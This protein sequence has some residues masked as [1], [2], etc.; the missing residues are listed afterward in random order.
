MSRYHLTA[1][2]RALY[3]VFIAPNLS[4]K[5][6]LLGQRP[7]ILAHSPAVVPQTPIRYKTYKKSE[8]A[9]RNALSDQYTLDGAINASHINLID[10]SGAFQPNF[11]TQRVSYN[12]VTHHLVLLQPGRVDEFGRSDPDHLPTCKIMSKMDLRAQHQKKLDIERRKAKGQAGSGPSP[13]NLE[14]NWAIASGDLK[15]RLE[16]LKGFLREGRKVEVLLGPKKRGRKATDEESKAVLKAVKDAVH[17]CKGAGEAKEP[18]GVV[19]GVMTLVFEGRKLEEN[20]ASG[21]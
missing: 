19:G 17:E 21:T 13:K 20:D 15:H 3:R 4:A 6:P 14:L 5:S 9:G 2:S 12:R 10:E 16:K 8:R 18:T 7:S 11:P 1:T